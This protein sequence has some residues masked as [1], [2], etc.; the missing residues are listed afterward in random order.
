MYWPDVCERTVRMVQELLE[1]IGY[2]PS[3]NAEANY[4]RLL[5]SQAATVEA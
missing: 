4:C 2:M 1:P 5:A 3:A